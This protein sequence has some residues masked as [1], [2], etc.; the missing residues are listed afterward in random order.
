MSGRDHSCEVCGRGGFN[1]PDGKCECPPDGSPDTARENTYSTRHPHEPEIP[2]VLAED[3]HC[4]VCRLLVRVEVLERALEKIARE[5]PD[6]E[7]IAR[8]ALRDGGK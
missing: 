6:C 4:R 7:Q 3:G 1:D 8:E 5:R 2:P